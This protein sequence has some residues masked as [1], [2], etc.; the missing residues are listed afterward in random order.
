MTPEFTTCQT[1]TAV[2]YSQIIMTCD[3]RDDDDAV[4]QVIAAELYPATR[5]M[6]GPYATLLF[7]QKKYDY[8]GFF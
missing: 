2:S 1:G 8:S 7:S 3:T 4:M 5:F 6:I